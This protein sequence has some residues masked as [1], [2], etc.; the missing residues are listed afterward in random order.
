MRVE[1][2]E[3]IPAKSNPFVRDG[4]H[5]GTRVASNVVVMH[6]TFDAQCASYIIVVNT[7][8]GERMR[9]TMFDGSPFGIVKEEAKS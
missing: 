3:S 4:Y 1:T 6:A 8:T 2:M 7:D 5:M 9:I